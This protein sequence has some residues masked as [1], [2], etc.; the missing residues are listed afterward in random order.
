TADLNEPPVTLHDILVRLPRTSQLASEATTVVPD[1]NA[2][3]RSV[4]RTFANVALGREW[5]LTG[6]E[7]SHDALV[8]RVGTDVGGGWGPGRLNIVEVTHRTDV[9]GRIFVAA[10][11]DV[12][13]PYGGC[14]LQ[15]GVRLEWSYTWTNL[16]QRQNNGDIDE[17]G[18]QFTFGVRF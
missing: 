12:E 6:D 8:M 16:L 3:V 17:L 4:N 11:A 2:T 5:Y 13:V 7:N 1:L 9:I 14:Y 10:H 15:G 18:L